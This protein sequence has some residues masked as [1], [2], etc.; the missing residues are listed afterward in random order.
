[1]VKNFEK[2]KDHVVTPRQLSR[3][4]DVN[5]LSSESDNPTPESQSTASPGLSQFLLNLND[6][7]CGTSS[8]RPGGMKKAKLKKK[9]DEIIIASMG[10][11]EENN[12]Q[13]MEILKKKMKIKWL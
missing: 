12:R 2:F 3:K 13:L 5:F 9:N 11:L 1:M 10:K 8:E 7:F 4:H 6:D